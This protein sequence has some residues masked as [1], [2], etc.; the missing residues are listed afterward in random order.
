MA[1]HRS[2]HRETSVTTGALLASI[3]VALWLLHYGFGIFA[4]WLWAMVIGGAWVLVGALFLFPD[5][6]I[7]HGVRSPAE[8]YYSGQYE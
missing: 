4:G 2:S 8:R 1:P 3:G 5:V 6:R 7:Y